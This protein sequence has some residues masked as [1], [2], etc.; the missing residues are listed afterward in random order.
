MTET[1]PRRAFLLDASAV[2]AVIFQEAGGDSVAQILSRS[3]ITELNLA[4]VL[5]VVTRDGHLRSR[6]DIAQDLKAAGLEVVS[7]EASPLRV[8]ELLSLPPVVKTKR[9]GKENRYRLSLGDA[10]CIAVAEYRGETLVITG[11]EAW[12]DLADRGDL[13]TLIQLFR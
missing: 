5:H 7:V 11:E 10:V 1:T 6:D 8:A 13:H 4:E 9:D 2:L 3:L 12:K